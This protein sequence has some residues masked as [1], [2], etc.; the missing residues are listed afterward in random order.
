MALGVVVGQAQFPA[1][2][3]VVFQAGLEHLVAVAD[4]AVVRFAEEGGALYRTELVIHRRNAAVEHRVVADELGFQQQSGV[5]VQLPRQRG[6]DHQA[7]VACMV[8]EAAVVF[9]GQVDPR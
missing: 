5:C 7:L 4:V 2:V 9:G 8:A 3:Q 6:A 1:V